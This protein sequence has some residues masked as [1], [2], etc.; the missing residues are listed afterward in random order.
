M[1]IVSKICLVSVF[2]NIGGGLFC[3]IL[4]IMGLYVFWVDEEKNRR[5]LAVPGVTLVFYGLN[6]LG[7]V[8]NFKKIILEDSSLTIRT[9][10]GKRKYN[11]HELRG[12][13]FRKGKSKQTSL[14]LPSGKILVLSHPFNKNQDEI[15]RVLQGIKK[16][17]SNN[18]KIDISKFISYN[19]K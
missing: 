9:L 18:E 12:F 10:S 2:K 7:E 8:R 6:L 3:L 16:Q 13:R 4:G 14:K 5:Y 15:D 11:W 19:F 1:K 17:R